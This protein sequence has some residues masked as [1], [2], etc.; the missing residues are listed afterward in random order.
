MRS[1]SRLTVTL[2][3]NRKGK[4]M[5]IMTPERK[6]ALANARRE[7]L[8]RA[9]KAGAPMR[10]YRAYGQYGIRP[11]DAP[12]SGESVAVISPVTLPEPECSGH[13]RHYDADTPCCYCGRIEA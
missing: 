4:T 5:D 2:T 1:A 13:C 11:A 12:Y 3:D 10:V 9:K 7:A 6:A 8:L